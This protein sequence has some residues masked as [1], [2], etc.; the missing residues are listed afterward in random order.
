VPRLTQIGVLQ[1]EL[2]ILTATATDLDIAGGVSAHLN[3]RRRDEV[4]VVLA[5][6][7]L[8]IVNV[9]LS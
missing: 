7:V 9:F 4:H 5:S 6:K 1:G 2:D 3:E 8:Q